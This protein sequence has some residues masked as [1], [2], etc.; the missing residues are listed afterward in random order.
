MQRWGRIPV[1]EVKAGGFPVSFNTEGSM[2]ERARALLLVAVALGGL[3][4]GVELARD[5]AAERRDAVAGLS[6]I[7]WA[8]NSGMGHYEVRDLRRRRRGGLD[9][10]HADAVDTLRARVRWLD[11]AGSGLLLLSVGMAASAAVVW[12]RERA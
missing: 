9:D 1:E 3:T 5:R 12:G 6:A 7:G 11:R 4:L 10:L 2:R 8:Y